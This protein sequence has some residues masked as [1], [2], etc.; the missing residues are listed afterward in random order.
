MSEQ[1]SVGG[2]VVCVL[3]LSVAVLPEAVADGMD[4]NLPLNIKFVKE[5]S[6]V[7]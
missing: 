3:T 2:G 7:L 4:P 6:P 1:S 5:E